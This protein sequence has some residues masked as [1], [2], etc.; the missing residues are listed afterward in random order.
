MRW[1]KRI[2]EPLG[3]GFVDAHVG[4]VVALQQTKVTAKPRRSYPPA[5]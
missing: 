5:G 3:G 4:E 2:R 1:L